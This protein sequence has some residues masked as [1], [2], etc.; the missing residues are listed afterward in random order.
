LGDRR[1]ANRLSILVPL[2]SL[3]IG[4]PEVLSDPASANWLNMS[5]R[6]LDALIVVVLLLAVAAASS[7]AE[8]VYM[9]LEGAA[10]RPIKGYLQIFMFVAWTFGAILI[11]AR[12]ADQP[13][14]ALLAGLGAVS[15][16]LLLIF[17]DTLLSMVASV[18][19][20][21]GDMI[22]IGDWIEMPSQ[23][24]D[25]TVI[26]VA[27]H[28][29]TVRNFD[30]T[31]TTI[32]TRAIVSNGFKNWRGM[33]ES[34]KRRIKRAIPIDV[35]SIAL[36]DEQHLA[37]LAHIPSLGDYLRKKRE[38]IAVWN[39]SEG[40]ENRHLTNIGT[41]RAYVDGYLR[42]H[43]DIDQTSTIMVRQLAP[44]ESGIPVEIYAF[45]TT[46]VWEEYEAIQAD[47]F[48]HLL[49]TLPRFGVRVHQAP[50]SGDFAN[51]VGSTRPP[52]A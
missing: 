27:L 24:A 15:A 32:P 6:I 10:E 33:Q 21:N 29:V 23:D 38:E 26:D 35:G 19:I 43:P 22:R 45:T 34:G 11:I 9:T 4:F 8:R 30:N 7:A 36:L 13:I 50:T 51:L 3:R 25:G 44:T 12:L 2:I 46:T 39:D 1:F 17:Q 20:T 49:A 14:G 48:D 5:D 47:I 42:N 41:F 31:I 16:V 28:T 40:H 37:D 52:T 18:R